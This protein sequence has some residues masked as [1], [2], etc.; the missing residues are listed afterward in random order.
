[1]RKNLLIFL[2]CIGICTCAY[3]FG[4]ISWREAKSTTMETL[5]AGICK[6][7]FPMVT[8]YDIPDGYL[9]CQDVGFLVMPVLGVIGQDKLLA[10]DDFE[11]EALEE[12]EL[13]DAS[14]DGSEDSY[15]SVTT[16]SHTHNDEMDLKETET[17]EVV[18][19]SEPT[20]YDEPSTETDALAGL[21]KQIVINRQKLLDFDY[22]KQTFYQVDNSTTIGSDLLNV[23]M[24][25]GKDLTLTEQAEGPQILI[26]HTHSQEGYDD[27]VSGDAST[28]VVAVGEYLAKL[29]NETYGIQV[30]HHKGQY[31]V[32]DHADSYAK[33]LP[34][35]KQILAENPSIEVV[36]DLHRDGVPDSTHLVTQIDGKP[37]AQI[38]FFNGLSR[39]TTGELAYLKNPY[40]EENLAFSF[41]MQLAA[42]E[43]FP[44]FARRI[45]L[46][47][48]RYNM[49]LCPKSL[50]VEVGAQ[51]NTFEEAKN[52]M[53]PLAILLAKV[54]KT[55]KVP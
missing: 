21:E 53:E 19:P 43:Y 30:L 29:L 36:I 33:A 25:L 3:R 35:I 28:S 48:Y 42:E 6:L 4:D 12:S 20:D 51:T 2:F 11:S 14:E 46:K 50:L 23:N 17:S 9:I 55:D 24:L 47:G 39:T 27:S 7:M 16:D 34:A 49:H 40:I 52:A 41:Q 37:V 32:E 8:L 1:M 18:E 44:G 10:Y 5:H 22:L 15:T 26:Y 54:L 38:M 13:L 45:Y 31:D